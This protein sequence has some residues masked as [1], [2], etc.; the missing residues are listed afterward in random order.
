MRYIRIS[1]RGFTNETAIYGIA[2]KGSKAA[3]ARLQSAIDNNVN[4]WCQPTPATDAEI[5]RT[6]R[7]A[8]QG[9]LGAEIPVLT[10]AEA[11]QMAEKY[12]PDYLR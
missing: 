1:P 6:R 12:E 7:Q 2:G 9:Y 8:A 3:L 11:I 4:A 10:P 5:R